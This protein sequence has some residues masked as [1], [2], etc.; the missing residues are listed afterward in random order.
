MAGQSMGK[1]K[2]TK[3]TVDAALA[4]E[5]R[6]ELWDADLKGFGLRV[7]PNGTKSFIVRYRPGAGGRT[8]PK[9]FISIGRYGIVTPDQAR[10]RARELLGAAARGDDPAGERW[11][12]R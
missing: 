4:R 10:R 1:V 9:R 2:I 8:A 12:R 11:R 6:F 7:E 3:R 5:S